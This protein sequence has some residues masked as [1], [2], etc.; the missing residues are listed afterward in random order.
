M[1]RIRTTIAVL[2]IL[3][4]VLPASAWA[5]AWN[6]I[7]PG[8]TK[9]VEVYEKIGKPTRD[10]DRGGDLSK[11]II[12]QG[13]ERPDGTKQVQIFFD[14]EDKVL[15]IHV[16]PKADLNREQII[17]TFGSKFDEK[18]NDSFKTYLFY[19]DEGVIVYFAEG[20]QTVAS[21]TYQKP[22]T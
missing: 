11:G 2:S 4:L 10:L 14:A 18:L 15:M 8:E 7:T 22:G 5:R 17:K 19:K 20:N 12:Y 1:N 16:F 3:S 13:K 21:I 9:R 6:N